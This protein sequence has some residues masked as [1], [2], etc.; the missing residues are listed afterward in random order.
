MELKSII[1]SILFTSQKPLTVREMR[2][3]LS[4]T[5]DKSED[6]FINSLKKTKDE[7]LQQCRMQDFL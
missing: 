4:A 6:I 7:E 5:A 1:E 2:E 3:V